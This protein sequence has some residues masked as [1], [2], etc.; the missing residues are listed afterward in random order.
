MARNVGS[1]IVK[2][3]VSVAKGNDLK[4]SSE[5]AEKRLGI[6]KTCQFF[7]KTSQK[8]SKCGCYLAVKTYLK[9]EHCPVH[10]W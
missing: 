1:S 6:C 3:V 7:D 8:C 10:K 2:N 9:A 5:E 4:I